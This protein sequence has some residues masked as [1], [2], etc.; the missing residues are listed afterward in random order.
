MTPGASGV[1]SCLSH[2][3]VRAIRVSGWVAAAFTCIGFGG[4][5]VLATDLFSHFRVAYAVALLAAL[6]TF[7]PEIKRR[8]WSSALLAFAFSLDIAVIA[9]LYVPPRH[10]PDGGSEGPSIRLL[11]FNIWRQ[12]HRDQDMLSFIESERPDVVSIQEVTGT[13]RTAMNHGFTDRYHVFSTGGDVLAVR[14]NAPSIRMCDFTSHKFPR[15]EVLEAHLIV[16]NHEVRVLSVHP[17]PSLRPAHAA[18][19]LAVF[20]SIAKLCRERPGPKILIGDL[21][22]TPWS[23]AFARLLHRAGLVDSEQGFGVQPTWRA[24]LGPVTGS[25]LWPVQLPIDHCLHA[26]EM[27]TLARGTGPACGSDHYPLL[28]TLQLQSQPQIPRKP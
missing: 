20:D 27:V 25:L 6:A 13:F 5:I 26:P 1:F 15:G 7:L 3:A 10:R 28:V 12:N 14:R 22:V 19:R 17:P 21:N 8:K 18:H 2:W 16:R 9:A 4:S 23:Y 24:F 11:Q